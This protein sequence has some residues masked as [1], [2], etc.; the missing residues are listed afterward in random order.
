[1]PQAV[2][3]AGTTPVVVPPFNSSGT[4]NVAGC[5]SGSSFSQAACFPITRELYNVMDYYEVVNTT[6][7][8]GSANNPAFNSVLSALF[9]DGN[10]ALC[11]S[12]FTIKAQGFAPIATNSSFNDLCGATTSD[13]R[14]QMNNTA[15]EG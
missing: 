3:S 12:T 11:Q 10:S 14:V 8:A 7:P 9:A 13:L 5:L 1:V 6:P 15:P 4:L 2:T